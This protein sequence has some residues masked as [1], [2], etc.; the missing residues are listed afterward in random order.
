MLFMIKFGFIYITLHKK[1]TKIKKMICNIDF[2]QLVYNTQNK[3]LYIN[4][5]VQSIKT[6]KTCLK[7]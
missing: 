4:C 2:V 3:R 6:K 5:Y 1:L 7:K